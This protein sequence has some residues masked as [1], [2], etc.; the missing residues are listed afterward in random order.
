[1]LDLAAPVLTTCGP[2]SLARSA[3][4]G[5]TTP[6]CIHSTFAPMSTASQGVPVVLVQKTGGVG[7]GRLT[8]LPFHRVAQAC[9]QRQA[10]ADGAD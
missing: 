6:G 8:P 7:T 4:S 3:T 5:L 10:G 9:R 2:A 1:V